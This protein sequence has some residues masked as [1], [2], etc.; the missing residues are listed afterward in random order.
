[1][2][3]S[4]QGGELEERV[5]RHVV[6]A[7]GTGGQASV[8]GEPVPRDVMVVGSGSLSRRR[9]SRTCVVR[10]VRKVDEKLDPLQRGDS[11]VHIAKK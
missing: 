2:E 1:M 9:G 11:A 5:K 4:A 8:S 7:G 3:E 6:Y 10:R